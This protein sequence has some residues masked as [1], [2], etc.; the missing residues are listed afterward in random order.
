ME[1][2]KSDTKCNKK[3]PSYALVVK[4]KV[5][6]YLLTET[7]GEITMN[8]RYSKVF[9]VLLIL[10]LVLSVFAFSVDGS[11]AA[12][13]PK[14]IAHRGWSSKAP[15]N[16]LPAFKLAAKNSGFYGVEF[17][18]WESSA[19]KSEEPLLLVMHE[20]NIS[21]MCGVN[22]N[23]RSITR[24]TLPKYTIK[25]DTNVKKYPGRKIP[26]VNQALNIIWKY[27]NGAVPVIELKH[28]LSSKALN[29]LF[30]LI[31]DHKVV[32]ISFDYY[33]VTDAVKLAKKRGVSSKVQTMY[34]K[35][36][37]SSGKYKATANK[38]K[39]AGVSC[40]SLKYGC[41]NKTLVR[42]FHSYGIKVCIWTVPDKSTA[43][44]YAKMGVDYITANGKVY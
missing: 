2:T 36:S 8:R 20:E 44:K 34:L 9:S 23:I 13:R 16:T 11:Y 5:I 1:S 24:K 26:T 28:R 21:R 17:D 4:V 31:G 29:Y 22:K 6:Y 42:T 32:I 33:A 35:S 15:E 25:S 41:V 18:I 27:S 38:L 39:K 10:S 14:Y 37:Q 7:I 40:I 3:Q 12:A 30:D 19:E 43:S